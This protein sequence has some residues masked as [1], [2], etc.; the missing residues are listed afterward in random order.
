[1]VPLRGRKTCATIALHMK[2]SRDFAQAELVLAGH[3]STRNADSSKPVYQHAAELRR[4]GLFLRV[5][6]AFWKQAPFLHDV[7]RNVSSPEVFVVPLM[8]SEGYFT[9]EVIPLELG[10]TRHRNSPLARV[11]CNRGRLI[12]YTLPIGTHP[13]ITSAL[14][15]RAQT[16]FPMDSIHQPCRPSQTALF[17]AGHGTSRHEN[18]RRSIEQ[19]VERIRALQIYAEVHAV[20]MEEKPRIDEIY[21]LTRKPDIIVVPFFI[22]DG[23]HVQE[24]IP[25]LL[26]ESEASV[27]ESLARGDPTWL[28]PTLRA[29]KR[30]W[31]TTSIGTE[32]YLADVILE[33]IR[34]IATCSPSDPGYHPC[35]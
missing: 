4:R 23:L 30:V 9:T 20:F 32:P 28:N 27:H 21:A 33:R 34:E 26:G 7:W 12:R 6:E 15:A 16:A 1:M 5:S 22:S 13:G 35:P 19:Q 25:I 3:G 10:L 17:I 2:D 14:L 31:F 8:I 24:D 18:S 11:H 29:G